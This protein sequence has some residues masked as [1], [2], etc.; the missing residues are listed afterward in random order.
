MPGAEF[1]D[2]NAAAV[3]ASQ[4]SL[5]GLLSSPV[6]STFQFDASAGV[7]HLLSRL[8]S[9]TSLSQLARLTAGYAGVLGADVLMISVLT[10]DGSALR[11]L[12]GPLG[13][14]SGAPY[15]LADYPVTAQALAERRI[16]PVYLPGPVNRGRAPEIWLDGGDEAEWAVLRRLSMSTGLLVPVLS[17]DVPIGLLECYGEKPARWTRR[18]IRSART[19][20]AMLGPVLDLLLSGR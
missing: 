2:V 15:R 16:A 18:Q 7:E 19:V 17:R 10:A 8:A 3:A 20:A 5:R 4:D 9:V 11:S 12:E 13:L 14:A 6:S 1:G